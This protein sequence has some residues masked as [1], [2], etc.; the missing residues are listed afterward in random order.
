MPDRN[1]PRAEFLVTPQLA[2]EWQTSERTLERLRQTGTGPPFI[3]AGRRVLYRRSDVEAWLAAHTYGST[4]EAEH[5][6]LGA[7]GRN[8][9]LRR[10]H[11]DAGNSTT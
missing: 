1:D 2:D 9:L 4:A 11:R 8:Q 7:G 3:K 5:S 6:R 10:F